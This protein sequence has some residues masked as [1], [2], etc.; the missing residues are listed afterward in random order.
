MVNQIIIKRA[1]I[2]IY[3][4]NVCG[5]LYFT[6]KMLLNSS[7]RDS[8]EAAGEMPPTVVITIGGGGCCGCEGP[9][10]EAV[11]AAK[12]FDDICNDL[13]PSLA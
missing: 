4:K 6:T 8:P 2:Y 7:W 12:Y 3:E 13:W 11:S 9:S 10:A 5:M 1:Y